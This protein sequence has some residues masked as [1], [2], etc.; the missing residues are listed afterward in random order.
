VGSDR[1]FST[2]HSRNK[3]TGSGNELPVFYRISSLR[4]GDE[5][6]GDADEAEK[7]RAKESKRKRFRNRVNDGTGEVQTLIREVNLLDVEGESIQSGGEAGEVEGEWCNAVWPYVRTSDVAVARSHWS[8]GREDE[9]AVEKDRDGVVGQH[10]QCAEVA[11]GCSDVEGGVVDVVSIRSDVAGCRARR[12]IE[13][14]PA[15]AADGGM[16][17]GAG[18]DVEGGGGSAVHCGTKW[19]IRDRRVAYAGVGGGGAVTAEENG[20]GVSGDEAAE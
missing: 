11:C 18:A 15:G 20:V 10:A 12:S 16:P 7:P 9:V 8:G 2:L 3:K 14:D 13:G 4:C 5:T 19:V 1:R 17:Y 6:A